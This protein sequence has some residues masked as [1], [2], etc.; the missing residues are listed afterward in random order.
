[1]VNWKLFGWKLK[2]N[3]NIFHLLEL[4]HGNIFSRFRKQLNCIW[5]K[6]TTKTFAIEFHLF[7]LDVGWEKLGWFHDFMFFQFFVGVSKSLN[8]IDF[9]REILIWSTFT[10]NNNILTRIA[11]LFLH[12]FLEF[13]FGKLF[14]IFLRFCD[15]Q[16][17]SEKWSR[18]ETFTSKLKI[19]S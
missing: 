2:S 16:I 1:M 13:V 17:I 18:E 14:I 9:W 10:H 5:F 15:F 11:Y 3:L 8:F 4:N 12:L 19:C 7:Y 6:N